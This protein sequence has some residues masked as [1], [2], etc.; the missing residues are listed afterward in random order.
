MEGRITTKR[1]QNGEARSGYAV[2][3]NKRVGDDPEILMTCNASYDFVS[4]GFDILL[5]DTTIKKDIYAG[6]FKGR[7][8]AEACLVGMVTAYSNRIMRESSA[9][10]KGSNENTGIEKSINEEGEENAS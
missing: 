2:L 4:E 6:H 8:S 5:S 10:R 1:I 3:L 9:E 7:E